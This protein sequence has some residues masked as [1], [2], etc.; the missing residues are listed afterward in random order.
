MS[1]CSEGILKVISGGEPGIR[2]LGGVNL[3]GFQD[4]YIRPTLS[5]LHVS[6]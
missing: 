1:I 5:I 6:V 3:A 4:R 2:T